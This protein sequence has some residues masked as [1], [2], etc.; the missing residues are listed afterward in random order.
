MKKILVLFLLISA[1]GF[2]PLYNNNLLNVEFSEI[3]LTG[4]VKINREIVSFLGLKETKNDMNNDISI[5]SSV[6][7]IETSKDAQGQPATY[8]T[9]I[10]VTIV[11]ENQNKQINTKTFDESFSYNNIENKYDLSV[12]QKDVQNNLVKKIIDDLIVY[13]NL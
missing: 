13:I 6:S 2:Q 9:N 10:V 8:R 12:Y 5:N 4:D 11:I 3:K 1:C 7:I